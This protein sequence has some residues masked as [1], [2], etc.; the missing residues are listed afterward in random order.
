VIEPVWL[1][2]ETVIY[3]N[4]EVV[5]ETGEPSFLRDRGLLESAVAKAI[6]RFHYEGVE[7]VVS[8]ATTL[9]F[10]LARNHP[11]EQGNKRTG[12]LAAVV[13]LETNGYAI[14]PDASL[15]LASSIIY[16]LEGGVTEEQF[17]AMLWTVVREIGEGGWGSHPKRPPKTP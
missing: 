4:E 17:A 10:G 11:F 1:S 15:A 7:D 14:E 9:L 3:I 8:L 16:V 5:R 12:F 6:N 13:F 2:A